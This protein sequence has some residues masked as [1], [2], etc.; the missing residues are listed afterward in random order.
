MM[1]DTFKACLII[2][3]FI[4][5]F[6]DIKVLPFKTQPFE[7]A[8]AAKHFSRYLKTLH[9]DSNGVVDPALIPGTLGPR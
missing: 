8:Q 1:Y 5:T 3:F 9:L 6:V 7:T 4:G 2:G